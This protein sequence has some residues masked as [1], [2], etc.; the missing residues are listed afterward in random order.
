LP[1]PDPFATEAWASAE[2][3][4]TLYSWLIVASSVYGM[5]A[6]HVPFLI[7][8]PWTTCDPY[9][10]P[11]GCVW[12]FHFW[13][14]PIVLYLLGFAWYERSK[15]AAERESRPRCSN[16][17]AFAAGELSLLLWNVAVDSTKAQRELGYRPTPAAEG[18]R[19]TVEAMTSWP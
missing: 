14:V 10:D 11:V 15:R 18:I 19:K 16:A 13:E 2:R 4:I 9:L 3:A 1:K 12:T 5:L 6:A 17:C 7:G 8:H